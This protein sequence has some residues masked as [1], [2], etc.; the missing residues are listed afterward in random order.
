VHGKKLK[1]FQHLPGRWRRFSIAAGAFFLAMAFALSPA[2]DGSRA[3]LVV[4]LARHAEKADDGRDPPLTPAGLERAGLLAA[5]LERQ[6]ITGIHSTDYYRTRDTA[7]PLAEKLGL[8]VSIY[9]P[10]K[11][12]ALLA[13]LMELGGVH[14]VVGH[15][16]T[17]PDLVTRLGGEPGDEIDEQS[18]YDRLY[19][20]TVL[21]DGTVETVLRRYGR[22]YEP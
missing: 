15:S 5:L 2:A 4:F 16:N 14:M 6:G 3:E 13:G 8:D 12:G 17:V 11:P 7:G 10:A 1:P 20:V 18:E 22:R 19:Q 21:D 9:D